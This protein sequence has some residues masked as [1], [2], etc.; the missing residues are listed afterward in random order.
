MMLECA[1]GS[2]S[3]SNGSNLSLKK[4]VTLTWAV[5][6]WKKDLLSPLLGNKPQ[7]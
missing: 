3:K 6:Y 2:N 5:L 4:L 1:A 7:I